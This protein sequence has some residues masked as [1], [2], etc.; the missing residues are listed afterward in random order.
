MNSRSTQLKVGT[1]L[2][3]LQL[4]IST[5]ISLVYTPAMLR[6]LGQTEYGL[7]NI[8]ATVISYVNL[9]NMGFAS[10]YVRFYSR[11]KARNDTEEIKKTNGLFLIVF[12][13][14]GL[15]ALIAGLTMAASAELIFSD[16]LSAGEYII[17]KKII[18]I[19]SIST[20][21]N[22]GT[23]LFSSMITA[24][25][26]FIFLKTVN[27][28]KTVLSPI[29]IWILL[30]NGYRSIMMASVTSALIIISDSFYV[31]YALRKLHVEF[32]FRNLKKDALIEVSMFS[33]FIALNSI[34]DQI[35]WSVDKILLGRFWG[36]KYTAIY[37]VAAQI[38]NI[39]MQ[40]STGVSNVFI[41]RI[42]RL[43]AEKKQDE[44]ITSIFIKI[45]RLQTIVLLPVILGFVFL[46]RQFISI[47]TPNGYEDAYYI[48]LLLMGPATVPYIQTA[49][50]SIQTAE[51][52]HQFRALLYALMAIINFI[53]SILLCRRFGGIGCAF[54]T[55]LSII[56]ANI[57]I[58]N[59]Y[60]HR[61]LKLNMIRFWKEELSFIPCIVMMSIVGVII[62]IW[63]P[64]HN[65]II[66]LLC[67]LIFVVV[68]FVTLWLFSLN[69]DEKNMIKSM[70]KS[71]DVNY[72]K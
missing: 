41:P 33:G 24:Q 6:L 39:Y 7:Y 14:I 16:G 19:L 13:V 67:I 45:G 52:K 47:W 63:V 51:N 53:V 21:Y 22:L 66:L 20:A 65:Y 36:A 8:A 58:M 72:D 50:V 55:A 37:S 59:I 4:I 57:I 15:L 2:T 54:G 27:L 10:S 31:V 23:S 70:L 62:C 26:E 12:I 48:A 30:L 69:A 40:L 60:Y 38:N 17:A 46:G 34:V 1:L 61:I 18:A 56:I 32:S 43:V 35:N 49:G 64:I 11:S 44:E 9:L 25:E 71:K 68:Y 3:Y 5:I 29:L 28:I 42:N